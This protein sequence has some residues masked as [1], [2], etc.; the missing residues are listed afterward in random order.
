MPMSFIRPS[1]GSI[2]SQPISKDD[3]NKDD[4]VIMYALKNPIASI[5]DTAF[6]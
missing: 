2:L 1:F 4:I 5:P 3:L 6:Q